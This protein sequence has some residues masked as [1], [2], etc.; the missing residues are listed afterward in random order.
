MVPQASWLQFE[1]NLLAY[2]QNGKLN[3]LSRYSEYC[4]GKVNI[5]VNKY[6]LI[7]TMLKLEYFCLYNLEHIFSEL[8]IYFGSIIKGLSRI[9]FKHKVLE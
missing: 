9:R 1:N 2:L 8:A 5:A 7:T 6:E 4:S 3:T